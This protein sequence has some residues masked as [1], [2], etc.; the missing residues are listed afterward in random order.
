MK[1]T[2]TLGGESYTYTPLGKYVVK[3]QGVCGGRP[4]FIRTRIPVSSALSRV[5]AGE[6]IDTI[7]MDLRN[8]VPREAIIEAIKL[9]NDSH[10]KL[11]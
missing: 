2:E 6:C 4:T 11:R 3:A 10:S 8:R 7:V 1:I 5:K 9:F